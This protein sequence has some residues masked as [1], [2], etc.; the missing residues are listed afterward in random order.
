MKKTIIYLLIFL[1]TFNGIGF[2]QF[3]QNKTFVDNDT[4]EIFDLTKNESYFNKVEQNKYIQK[5]RIEIRGHIGLYNQKNRVKI[6]DEHGEGF[7]IGYYEL[8]Q[9]IG[10]PNKSNNKIVITDEAGQEKIIGFFDKKVSKEIFSDG[11]FNII[12]SEGIH[13]QNN[14]NDISYEKHHF[15]PKEEK[16]GVTIGVQE[17]KEIFEETYNMKGEKIKTRYGLIGDNNTIKMYRDY[18]KERAGK[19]ITVKHEDY[20]IVTKYD[21]NGKMISR[22]KKI[23]EDIKQKKDSFKGFEGSTMKEKYENNRLINDE[24]MKNKENFLN[25]NSGSLFDEIGIDGSFENMQKKIN[26]RW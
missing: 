20:S 18:E 24:F 22:K 3:N 23:I 21:E 26:D 9:E 12:H 2:A 7:L 1:I 11:S 16:T 17:G 8:E 10:N 25:G 19:T 15:N 4:G 13:T 5:K 6:P 14:N